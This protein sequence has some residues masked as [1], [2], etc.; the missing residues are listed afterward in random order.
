MSQPRAGDLAITF[1]VDANT[2]M[3]G[4]GLTTAMGAIRAFAGARTPATELGLI[5][6]SSQ[7]SM[8]L[9]P[10]TD[11]PTI[12][13]AL[14]VTP[15]I[16]SGSRPRRRCTGGR[17]SRSCASPSAIVPVAVV[18]SDGVGLEP[19]TA[20][21]RATRP[22]AS[23][24]GHHRRAAGRGRDARVAGRAQRKQAPRHLRAGDPDR[25]RGEGRVQALVA[26]G[27]H[28]DRAAGARTI[29]GVSVAVQGTSSRR[30]RAT[31]QATYQA[32]PAADAPSPAADQAHAAGST[33]AHPHSGTDRV[34][35]D[36]HAQARCLAAVAVPGFTTTRPAATPPAAVPRRLL[37]Q[38]RQRS[39]SPR[40]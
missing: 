16:G 34:A 38:R 9:A 12:A 28:R 20:A 21:Q 37:A 4:E 26:A 13:Q 6:F 31:V 40:C 33:A 17:S 24:P 18:I 30:A 23:H 35:R 5:S 29:T 25:G 3:R 1:V 39:S 11:A 32:P 2:S 22:R 19:I 27:Q 36:L 7:P 15:T 8:L 14:E 10:T